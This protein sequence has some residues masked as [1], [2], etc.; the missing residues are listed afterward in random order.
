MQ[1]YVH[2]DACNGGIGGYVFQRGD[3][4][5]EYPIGFLS[6][7]LKGAELGWSTFEQECFAIHQTLKKFSY[8]LRDVKFTIRTDHRNLLYMNNEASSKV[9][10]WKWDIQD[11]DF[12][13]EHIAGTSNIA[14]DLFS[15]LCALNTVETSTSSSSNTTSSGVETTNNSVEQMEI[16]LHKFTTSSYLLALNAM[17]QTEPLKPWMKDNRPKTDEE[18]Y[19]IIQSVHGWGCQND[20]GTITAGTHGHQGVERTLTLLKDKVPPSKWW[21]SMRQDVK[22]FIRDCPNCQFMQAA[23]LSITQ[24][25]QINPYNVVQGRPMDRIYIDTIGPFPQDE[26]GNR[27]IM[28]FIDVFSRFVEL[29]AV[30]DLT[31]LTAAKKVVEFAGRYGVPDQILT[32]N[33]T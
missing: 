17:R 2:T 32:D 20:D 18:V 10:R 22:Q 19:K 8:L 4:G 6:K 30:R 9:L 31:A 15:R 25:P 23:K 3:D 16:D 5:T 1:V 26:E 28:V 13:V 11:F 12:Q 27:Y 29:Y 14:A 24:R 7:T 33:G 21:Y